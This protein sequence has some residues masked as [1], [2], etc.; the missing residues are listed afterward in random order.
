M[1]RSD[2]VYLDPKGKPE[3]FAQCRS[4]KMFIQSK[5]VCSLLGMGVKINGGMSCTQYA[6]GKADEIELAHVSKSFT[7]EEVGLVDREVRCENC[8]FFESS[9]NDCLLF[10]TLNISHKV[11][12][13]GCCNAQEASDKKESNK[14]LKVDHSKQLVIK[15]T[16]SPFNK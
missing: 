12:K 9:D 11:N 10:K 2:L 4:C 15:R 8:E 16:T 1:K 6:F 5:G 7:Q 3:D 13:H 14:K